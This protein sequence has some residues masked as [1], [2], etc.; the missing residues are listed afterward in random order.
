MTEQLA[1]MPREQFPKQVP[2]SPLAARLAIAQDVIKHLDSKKLRAHRGIYI[3]FLEYDDNGYTDS[4]E[5]LATSL[6]MPES[7]LICNVCAIGAACMVAVGLYDEAET[8]EEEW[9]RAL[10]GDDDGEELNPLDIGLDSLGMHE[11]L[12]QWFSAKQLAMIECA[13]EGS[14][15]WGAEGLSDTLR[16]KAADFRPSDEDQNEYSSE[17]TLRDIFQN[18]LDNDGTFI[19]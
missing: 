4:F 14:A 9:Y 10:E 12:G 17:E 19:P 16:E 11:V 18:I 6:Y 2:S 13:F 8:L 5:Q 15:D 3:G 7:K 1:L